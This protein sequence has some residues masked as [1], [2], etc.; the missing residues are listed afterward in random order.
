MDDFMDPFLSSSSWSEL[1]TSSRSSWAGTIASQANGLLT[2]SVESYVGDE[3]NLTV[4]VIPS[5]HIMGNV[6]AEDS[7]L[8]AH[9]ENSS[10]FTEGNLKYLSQHELTTQSSHPQHDNGTCDSNFSL[11]GVFESDS[12]SESYGRELNTSCSV[13]LSH[14]ALT[15]SSSIESNGSEPSKFAQSLGDTHS[16]SSVPSMWPPSYSGVSSFIDQGE[17]QGFGFQGV[18]SDA[19]GLGKTYIEND[20]YPHL[21]NSAAASLHVRN[22]IFKFI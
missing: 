13:T 9:S 14:S 21:N 1:N 17:L 5:P 20:K 10:V 19:D 12:T 22:L 11:K 18:E 4:S 6:A 3:K 7:D 8:H 15:M 2:H 16:I